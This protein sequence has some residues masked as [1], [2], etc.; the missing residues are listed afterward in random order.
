MTCTPRVSESNDF[1]SSTDEAM[2][3][4][5]ILDRGRERAG[6][7]GRGGERGGDATKGQ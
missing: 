3:M 7:G 5:L 6:E 4:L 1:C 2:Q